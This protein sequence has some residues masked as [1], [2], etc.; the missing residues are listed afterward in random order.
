MSDHPQDRVPPVDGD[1]DADADATKPQPEAHREIDPRELLL[2]FGSDTT[3]LLVDVGGEH[4]FESAL[5]PRQEDLVRWP[6]EENARHEDI[7]IEHDLHRAPRTF[8]TARATSDT[9]SPASRACRRA[10]AAMAANSFRAGVA[11]VLRITTSRSPMTTNCA[12]AF[13][14]SRLRTA[15]GMTTCPF[16]DMRVVSMFSIRDTSP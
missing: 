9:C 15:S 4:E 16:D 12:P 2:E 7:R 3:V 5:T 13:N 6:S 8:R 11:I 1:A 10:L 14:P